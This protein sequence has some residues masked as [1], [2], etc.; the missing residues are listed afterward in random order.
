[1]AASSTTPTAD[2][3]EAAGG[4]GNLVVLIGPITGAPEE[5]SVGDGRAL[6]FDVATTVCAAGDRSRR[7]DVPVNWLDPPAADAAVLV[8]GLEVLVVGTV[9]RRFFRSGGVTTSR[10]EVVPD[11]VVPARRRASV[12]SA[13]AAVAARLQPV[14]G[15]AK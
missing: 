2:P 3:S 9:R 13:L 14:P 6:Q 4:A 11:R 5:R 12:R 1:M 10:T 7:V 8:P 15:S